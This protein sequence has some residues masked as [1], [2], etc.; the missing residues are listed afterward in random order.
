MAEQ[1]AKA[2]PQASSSSDCSFKEVGALAFIRLTQLPEKIAVFQNEY[3]YCFKLDIWNQNEGWV[4]HAVSAKCYR[5]LTTCHKT[6]DISNLKFISPVVWGKPKSRDYCFFCLIVTTGFNSKSKYIMNYIYPLNVMS[7]SFIE[8]NC[9]RPMKL[10]SDVEKAK[11]TSGKAKI[12]S[13]SETTEE[14]NGESSATDQDYKKTNGVLQ[15][16][17]QDELNDLGLHLG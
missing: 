15:K 8:T 12:T 13:G 6:R 5:I 14:S 9:G 11:I 16:F 10:N 7:A 3:L 4:P 2:D 17:C 1:G